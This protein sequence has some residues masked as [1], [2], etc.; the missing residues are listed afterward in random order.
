[1]KKQRQSNIELLR[2]LAMLFVLI[3]HADFIALGAPD[4]SDWASRPMGVVSQYLFECLA[5]CCVDVFVLISGWFGI[6]FSFRKL[7]TFLFQVGFFSVGLFI[8][9]MAFVP[10]KAF[11]IE[12]AKSVFLLNGG[13][14]WFVKAYVVLMILSPMLNA[15]CNHTPRREFKAILLTYL[16]VMLVYGWLEPASV[17]FSM[18]GC[19]ALSF[20]GLYLIGRYMKMYRPTFT[21][22]SMK[23]DGLS[24]LAFSLSMVLACVLLIRHGIRPTLD[25]RLLS[26]GCPLVI[27]AA[28]YLLLFFSKWNFSNRVVNKMSVSC[29]AVYLFHCNLFLFPLYKD[30]ARKTNEM[31]GALSVAIFLLVVY[32]IAI[33]IDR[34]RLF[35]WRKLECKL[36]DAR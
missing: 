6:K 29:L 19:T 7:G 36:D 15:F 11:T 4:V 34:I 16:L 17:S 20:V 13:D 8:A 27:L 33:S 22:N 28:I 23:R 9:A 10:Q 18:N 5:I 14:Y 32:V 26:Y 1:M 25:S 2:L 3:V 31:G 21:T 35:L 24:Y 30:F 12:G